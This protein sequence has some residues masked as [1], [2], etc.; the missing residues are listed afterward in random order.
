MFKN[1][2]KLTSKSIL[3]CGVAI[4]AFSC[5]PEDGK[6]GAQGI[7]GEKGE[8][9]DKGDQGIQG[10]QGITGT[11]G[12]VG[13][14]G[15]IGPIGPVG[16]SG[17]GFDDVTTYGFISLVTS[18]KDSDEIPFSQ[19]TMFKYTTGD[20][21][22]TSVLYRS[23]NGDG[24]T[25]LGFDI[26]RIISAGDVHNYGGNIYIHV[27]VSDFGTA[28]QQVSVYLNGSYPV[29]NADGKYLNY[30]SYMDSADANT[31][32]SDIQDFIISEFSYDDTTKKLKFKFSYTN[33]YSGVT[34]SGVVDI[35]AAESANG[36]IL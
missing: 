15:P 7:Q 3:A 32:S 36:Y 16:A 13:Q 10:I 5:T 30:Y 19:K 12:A 18:G 4:L 1:L 35:V 23:V 31:V 11:T 26:S 33:T 27:G 2:Q 34:V 21:M 29:I 14:T 28:T 20:V 25:D 24:N 8:K 9:G 6:D 17:L 22:D